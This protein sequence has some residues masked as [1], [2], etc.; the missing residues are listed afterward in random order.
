LIYSADCDREFKKKQLGVFM[1]TAANSFYDWI[2]DVP[3][4]RPNENRDPKDPLVILY[5]LRGPVLI[6]TICAVAAFVFESSL[7][8][9]AASFAAAHLAARVTQTLAKPSTSLKQIEEFGL[10]LLR[11]WPYFYFVASIVA[12]I[13]CKIS[14]LFSIILGGCAGFLNGLTIELYT[15]SAQLENQEAQ[16]RTLQP[17]EI[18]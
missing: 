5:N 16:R 11:N 6:T 7:L 2:V 12:V 1:F 9:V 8:T 15:Q 3:A 18:E 10:S 17:G 4:L 13:F 14:P